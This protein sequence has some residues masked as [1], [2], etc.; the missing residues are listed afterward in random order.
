MS[1]GSKPSLMVL[2]EARLSTKSLAMPDLKDSYGGFPAS[3]RP[4]SLRG[5]SMGNS[6]D[7]WRYKAMLSSLEALKMEQNSSE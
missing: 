6:F 7:S 5:G 2:W 4:L 3:C 1:F